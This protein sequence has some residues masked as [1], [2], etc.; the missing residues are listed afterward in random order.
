MMVG[1]PYPKKKNDALPGDPQ[2]ESDEMV[3]V[4]TSTSSLGGTTLQNERTGNPG[5]KAWFYAKIS[6]VSLDLVRPGA[7]S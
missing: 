2:I 6:Q 4:W 1:R 7:F 3:I 5:L